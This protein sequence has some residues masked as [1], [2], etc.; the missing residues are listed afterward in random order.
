MNVVDSSGWLEYFA[1]GRNADFFAPS[2]ETPAELIVSTISILEVFKCVLREKG[3]R[4]ALSAVGL[5]TSG[6]VAVL[7]MAVALRAAKVGVDL[8]LP[9]ADSVMLATARQFSATLWTQD[10]DFRKIDGVKYCRK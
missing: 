9:L 6:Q 1:N 8:K 3:E 10:A 4:E 7:D 5:M 2:I